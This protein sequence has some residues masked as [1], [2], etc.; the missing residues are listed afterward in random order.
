[1]L[2]KIQTPEKLAKRRRKTFHQKQGW[3]VLRPS[4]DPH[5]TSLRADYGTQRGHA[6][7]PVQNQNRKRAKIYY[8]VGYQK[9]NAANSH[10]GLQSGPD[11]RQ[12]CPA[13]MVRAFAPSGSMRHTTRH[14]V[15]GKPYSVVA[16]LTL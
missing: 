4:D 3:Q 12:N 15:Y 5:F 11:A 1:M 14:G 13:T 7:G 16:T 2:D 6:V 8:G 9:D 10:A